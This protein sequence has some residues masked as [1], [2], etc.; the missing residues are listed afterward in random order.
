[1]FLWRKDCILNSQPI[2]CEK[3]FLKSVMS[4]QLLTVF[5]N[6]LRWE[7]SET[8]SVWSMYWSFNKIHATEPFVCSEYNF[9]FNPTN[10][11]TI[12]PLI[13]SLN[14]KTTRWFLQLNSGWEIKV[15]I[16]MF[17]SCQL[18]VS[19]I[20]F[21]IVNEAVGVSIQQLKVQRRLHFHIL[22]IKHE[23][24]GKIKY[25]SPD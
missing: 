4:L 18:I 20:I 8:E 9:G 2:S 13:S 3:S 7:S 25:N 12:L 17:I 19:I 24:L 15:W 21:D 1:M 23:L 5:G 16:Q 22:K 10:S 6:A 11:E 14:F